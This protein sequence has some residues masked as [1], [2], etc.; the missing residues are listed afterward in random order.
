M[1]PLP[2]FSRACLR[3]FASLLFLQFLLLLA[4]R[5]LTEPCIT[6]RAKLGHS[7]LIRKNLEIPCTKPT[8]EE[9]T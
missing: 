3:C 7:P 6:D 8:L 4:G 2:S 5:M 1:T 9:I